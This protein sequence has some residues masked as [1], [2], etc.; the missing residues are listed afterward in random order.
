MHV[1]L[2]AGQA[3]R[4]LGLL[5]LRGRRHQAG[6]SKRDM[7]AL[8]RP[9]DNLAMMRAVILTAAAMASFACPAHAVERGQCL[10]TAEMVAQ[11]R[12]EGQRAVVTGEAVM[13]GAANLAAPLAITYS[14]NPSGSRGYELST[15]RRAGTEVLCVTEVLADVRLADPA[16]REVRAFHLPGGVSDAEARRIGSD[17][18][19]PNARGFNAM[20]DASAGSGGYVILQARIVGTDGETL[21][22][23][24]LPRTLE[25]LVDRADARGISTLTYVMR[26][27]G[28]TPYGRELLGL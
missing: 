16:R 17:E 18:G 15:Q 9:A 11:L 23:L 20:L 4:Q 25:T 3:F 22:A 19:I 6:R 27:S 13:V 5:Q 24:N 10:P 26:R 1:L 12:S 28:L 8:Q 14:M 7:P 2:R 21:S